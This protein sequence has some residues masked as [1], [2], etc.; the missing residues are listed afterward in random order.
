MGV[1]CLLDS[2]VSIADLEAS[3]EAGSALA[4]AIAASTDSQSIAVSMAAE[5][6]TMLP[7]QLYQCIGHQFTVVDSTAAT[8]TVVVDS[9]VA[10]IAED[11]VGRQNWRKPTT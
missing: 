2:I 4:S 11:A 8:F 1:E 10:A 5:F 3:V 7:V 9:T 6:P